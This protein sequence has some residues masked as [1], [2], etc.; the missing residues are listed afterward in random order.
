MN[1]TRRLFVTIQA[2]NI[3][4]AS[5]TMEDIKRNLPSGKYKTTQNRAGESADWRHFNLVVNAD[6]NKA[7]RYVKCEMCGT[8]MRY[9]SRE[10][11]NSGL[12]GRGQRVQDAG[13]CGW[14]A[15][16]YYWLGYFFLKENYTAGQSKDHREVRCILSQRYKTISWH[17]KQA[18]VT[19]WMYLQF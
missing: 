8:L 13:C 6:N 18:A 5:L 19:A 3:H 12:Q 15:D 14:F 11:G 2:V 10:T 17:L 1:A 4:A 16:C 7:A 9:D